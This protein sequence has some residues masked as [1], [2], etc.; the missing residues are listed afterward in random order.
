MDLHVGPD[1][2]TEAEAAAVEAVVAPVGPA[3]LTAVPSG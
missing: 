2:A 1:L 3:V